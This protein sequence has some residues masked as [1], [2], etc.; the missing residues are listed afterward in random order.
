MLLPPMVD[1]TKM[2]AGVGSA[3][4]TLGFGDPVA[5]KEHARLWVVSGSGELH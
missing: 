2:A 5:T 3:P 1:E 4:T